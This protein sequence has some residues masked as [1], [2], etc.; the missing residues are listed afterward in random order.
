MR[1]R[2]FLAAAAGTAVG[3]FLPGS[4]T[5]VLASTQPA[6]W[7]LGR[8][9][10]NADALPGMPLTITGT[11][12]EALRGT[13]FR[14]GPARTER[15]GV[16]YRHLFD[17]D[18]MVQRYAFDGT[19][20]SHTARYVQT[21]KYVREQAA[22]RFLYS[23]AGTHLP[24][25]EPSGNND[26]GNVANTSL[27]PW[28]DE[29]LALWEGGSA[30]RLDPQSLDTL[31]RKDWRDDLKHMPFSAHPLIDADGTMWNFGSAP[32]AGK[33]GTLF[34]YRIAPRTGIRAVEAVRLPA[35][36]YLHSFAMSER[37]L[38]FYLGAHQFTGRGDTFVDSFQ[39][40]PEN[41]S[42]VLVIDKNDLSA[43]RFIDAPAGFTF[44]NA[45][46]WDAGTD[47]MLQLCLYPTAGIM[48]SG[49]VGMMAADA[50]AAYPAFPR[51]YFVTL[52][53]DLSKNRADVERSDTMLEFPCVDTQVA[54][55][56]AAVFGVS[57]RRDED[58]TYS[59]ALVRLRPDGREDSRF[60]FPAQHMVE[61]PLFVEN[62]TGG[63][64]VGTFL[65]LARRQSGVYVFDAA[66][67]DRGPLAMARMAR[68]VPLGFHG[69]FVAA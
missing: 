40:S 4:A 55:G 46:A 3:C 42:R 38:V 33:N 29:L 18:G 61:E 35:A 8:Q 11:W 43:Q 17:G 62:D 7:T 30:Y 59:D 52:R 44:H 27:L 47:V 67:L 16:R 19:S 66:N 65:D 21:Q 41:G 53:V 51:S 45:Q 9:S 63:W 50:S 69:C 23:G 28:D 58:V 1:R 5:R 32:Y 12:P 54:P 64:L 6:N 31:G 2:S 22:G 60:D 26:S 37:Y 49:M 20:V 39:W 48:Q 68:H 36:S 13:L 15:A 57:H 56:T 34:V 10:M 14:N 25:A 24:D